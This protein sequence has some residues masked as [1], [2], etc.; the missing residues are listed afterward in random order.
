MADQ[1]DQEW[2]AELQR[3]GSKGSSQSKGGSPRG[4]AGSS[5]G[6]HSQ[7]SFL[8]TLG[9]GGPPSSQSSLGGFR[10]SVDVGGR[11]ADGP[12]SV[13]DVGGPG[14]FEGVPD[15]VFNQS[16]A[17][18]GQVFKFFWTMIIKNRSGHFVL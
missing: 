13:D 15:A 3:Q 16:P 11:S 14:S 8:G 9:L 17:V 12:P 4:K 2:A 10:Q 6:G 18:G 5:K 7:P 1:D